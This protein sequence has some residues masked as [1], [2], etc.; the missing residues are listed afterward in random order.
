MNDFENTINRAINKASQ[1]LILEFRNELKAQGHVNTGKLS[2][3]I[4]YEINDIVLGV[5]SDF[6]MLD[7][8]FAIDTGIEANRIPFSKGSG[9]GSSKYI[10]GLVNYFISKGKGV[11]AAKRA[12]FATA[13]IHKR[14]GMPTKASSRFS[15]TGKRTQ[16]IDI[17][18][19]RV[20]EQIEKILIYDLADEIE[21]SF[22]LLYKKIPI[23]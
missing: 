10:Q 3:S 2:D 18:Y 5:I 22:E 8:G 4:S 16:F 9:A 12:A 1:L 21:M 6:Y 17:A 7:Y 14:E 23:K 20:K 15:K 11:K 19:D 13:T